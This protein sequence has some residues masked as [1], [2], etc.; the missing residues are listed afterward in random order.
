MH[1]NKN[2]QPPMGNMH[3]N[4]IWVKY[5]HQQ[6]MKE[7]YRFAKTLQQNKYSL[8]QFEAVHLLECHK[9][10]QKNLF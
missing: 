1:L 10:I 4:Q 2:I 6:N 3:H 9:A 7:Q 5:F 8:L